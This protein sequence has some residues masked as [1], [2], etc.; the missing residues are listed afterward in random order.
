M[1][2]ITSMKIPAKKNKI[3]ALNRTKISSLPTRSH[4]TFM[5]CPITAGCRQS[6]L[7]RRAFGLRFG[8]DIRLCAA[9]GFTLLPT[10]FAR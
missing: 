9:A 8:S 6:L 5:P 7:A 2:G 4:G 1:L 10:H 3:P